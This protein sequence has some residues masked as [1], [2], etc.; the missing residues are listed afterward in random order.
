MAQA[1][2]GL[3]FVATDRARMAVS[4]HPKYWSRELKQTMTSIITIMNFRHRAPKF[5][6][7]NATISA[8]R[9][10]MRTKMWL[11]PNGVESTIAETTNTA[12]RLIVNQIKLFSLLLRGTA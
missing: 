12:T 11:S 3:P 8:A 9:I 10:T 1:R 2:C 5:R 4:V 7:V 6:L